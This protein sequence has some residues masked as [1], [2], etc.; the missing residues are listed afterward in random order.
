[1]TI[2]DV[3]KL[4][5]KLNEIAYA[6]QQDNSITFEPFSLIANGGEIGI[7]FLDS[8]LWDSENTPTDSI[9]ELTRLIAEEMEK[10]A[11]PLKQVLS[12]DYAKALET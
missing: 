12:I 8:P 2:V 4:V 7:R 11:I 10:I 6:E 3:E 1:M 9:K 5:A